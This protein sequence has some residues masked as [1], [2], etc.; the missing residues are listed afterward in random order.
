MDHVGFGDGAA[1]AHRDGDFA[2]AEHFVDPRGMSCLGEEGERRAA[3]G[4]TVAAEHGSPDHRLRRGDRGVGV[5]HGGVGDEA[6]FDDDLRLDAEKGRAP[7]HQIGDFAHFD[8]ADVVAE[9]VGDGRVD[10]VFGNVTF[11]AGV[12]VVARLFGQATALH[13]HLVRGLPGAQDHLAD[14]AHG[15][16]IRRHHAQ[17]AQIVENVFG[18]DGL[19][20]DARLGEGQ[21]FGDGRIQVMAD[22]EHVEMLVDGVDGEGPRRVGGRG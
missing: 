9:A 21:V 1:V 16:R 5:A 4:A 14:A 6:A 20:A 3:H 8:G 10:G 18:G 17:R 7:Q 19:G 11:D 2:Q 22:H 12:V 13:F 15:L